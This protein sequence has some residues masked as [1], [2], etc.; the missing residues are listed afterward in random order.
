MEIIWVAISYEPLG[1]TVIQLIFI[2]NQSSC[3]DFTVAVM[4]NACACN[5]WN[6]VMILCF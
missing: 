4:D 1:T 6:Q 2:W 5:E 3:R